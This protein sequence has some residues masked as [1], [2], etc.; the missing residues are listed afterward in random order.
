MGG[1]SK[2]ET[3]IQNL[4]ECSEKSERREFKLIVKKN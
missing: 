4:V 2:E 1:E 3:A